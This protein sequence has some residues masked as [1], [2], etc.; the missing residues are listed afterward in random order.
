MTQWRAVYRG[1]TVTHRD[2]RVCRWQEYTIGN[3]R[4]PVKAWGYWY[5]EPADP[6]GT[7]RWCGRHER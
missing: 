5:S 1:D 7:R 6:E 2:G 4:N 3:I